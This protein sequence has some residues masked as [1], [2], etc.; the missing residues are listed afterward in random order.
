MLATLETYRNSLLG[1]EPNMNR[2]VVVYDEYHFLQDESRGSAWEE[3][4]IL[5]PKGS[6]LVLLSASVPNS[7]EFAEWIEKLTGKKK[8]CKICLAESNKQK[9]IF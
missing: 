2:R 7:E 6:Q 1:I 5:T 4:L 9:L 8:K 3:S